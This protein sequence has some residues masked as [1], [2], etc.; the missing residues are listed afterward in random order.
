MS[1]NKFDKINLKN[2]GA[3][4]KLNY[5]GNFRNNVDYNSNYDSSNKLRLAQ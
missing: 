4:N 1:K 5:E 3:Y 2:K